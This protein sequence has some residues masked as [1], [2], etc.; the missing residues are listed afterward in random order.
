MTTVLTN[1]VIDEAYIL[2]EQKL[3]SRH[4]L[5]HNRVDGLL[6]DFLAHQSDPDK[7]G[8]QHTEEVDTPQPNIQNQ[9]VKF[10]KR[11]LIKRMELPIMSKAN[12][13]KL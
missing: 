12:T 9:S 2:S 5:G 6:F 1:K 7:N 3:V 4:R 11:Q 10:P 13:S 8:D